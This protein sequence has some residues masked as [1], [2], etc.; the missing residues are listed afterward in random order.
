MKPIFLSLLLWLS[1][2]SIGR[3]QQSTEQKIDSLE[4]WLNHHT[5]LDTARIENMTWLEYRYIGY[6]PEK[7]GRFIGQIMSMSRRLNYTEGILDG[8]S[9]TMQL[10]NRNHQYEKALQTAM[11]ARTLARQK[12]VVRH[13][14]AALMFS[15]QIYNTV[16]KAH[17]KAIALY[18]E[19]EG[20]LL[21]PDGMEHPEKIAHKRVLIKLYND[22]GTFYQDKKAYKQA[23]PYFQK[24]MPILGLE[25][26]DIR[27]MLEP[28]LKANL[29]NAYLGIG[30]FKQAE[31]AVEDG[32]ELSMKSKSTYVLSFLYR[33]KSDVLRETGRLAEAEKTLALSR[34]ALKK[35]GESIVD[36]YNLQQSYYKLYYQKGDFKSAFAHLQEANSLSDS[37]HNKELAE[38]TTELETR[39]ESVRKEARIQ[40]MQ[41][42]TQLVESQNRLYQTIMT[43]LVILLVGAGLALWQLNR[44]KQQVDR[45]N[46]QRDRLFSYVAHDLRGPIMSLQTLTQTVQHDLQEVNIEQINTWVSVV[47][48][49]ATSLYA[50]VDNLLNWTLSQR[51]RLVSRPEKLIAE[52]EIELVVDSLASTARLKGVHIEVDY[53]QETQ[54]YADPSA[55][56]TIIR[57]LLCNAI[58]FTP[59][60]G[61]VQIKVNKSESQV[62]IDVIDNGIGISTD[63]LSHLFKQEKQKSLSGNMTGKGVGLGL[64]L[65]QRLAELNNG[66]ISVESSLGQ[67]SSFKVLLKSG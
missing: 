53:S 10:A 4:R 15:A 5:T 38:R 61:L 64:Y 51:D 59:N 67:G 2:V 29:A 1:I 44:A 25:S 41:V 22:I 28:T 11:E 63:E 55:V 32:L 54:L 65:C 19:A 47:Q 43:A 34:E 57:N 27:G 18:K 26:E 58:K 8:L 3:S 30:D 56:Q 33:I 50:L 7:S 37:I 49:S 45:A 24:A 17:D 40:Q 66:R 62:S 9:L 23:I 48:K 13:E 12:G 46:H 36:A 21:P 60:G 42:K 14:A 6:Y 31:L 39:Y 35:S 16:L 52:H 20:L